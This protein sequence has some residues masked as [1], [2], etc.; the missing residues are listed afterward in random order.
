MKEKKEFATKL[1]LVANILLFIIKIIA[2]LVSNSIALLSDAANSL[3]DIVASAIIY[4]AVKIAELHPDENHPFGHRSAEPIAGLIIAIFTSILA[5]ELFKESVMRF[6]V[7]EVTTI[8]LFP[9]IVL[10]VT[11]VTKFFL[12]I[13]FNKLNRNSPA[14]QAYAVDSRN[15]VLMSSVALGGII[16]NLLGIAEF[17]AFAGAAISIWI[18]VSGYKLARENID[19]LMAKAPSDK[20]LL[21]LKRRALNVKGVVGVND[22]RAYY[23]GNYLHVELH[24]E[25]DEKISTKKS[26]QICKD[27]EAKLESLKYVTKGFIH[28]DPVHVNGKH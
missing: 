9:I 18:F 19:F 10:I 13:Y 15:D 14:M 21:T 22:I 11:I 23:V 1:G 2:G 26:H 20:I 3:L 12:F 7:V 5:F 28:I 16:L 25:V 4:F 8:T 27:V 24:A 17:D 6:F